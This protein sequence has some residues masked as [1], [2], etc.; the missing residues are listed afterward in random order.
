MQ[1]RPIRTSRTKDTEKRRTE[2]VR[3]LKKGHYA[4]E[5]AQSIGC[6]TQRVYQIK[7]ELAGVKP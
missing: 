3:R 6:S 4:R 7:K 1:V 5:I 2:I